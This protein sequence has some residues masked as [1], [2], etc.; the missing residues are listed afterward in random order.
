ME[1]QVCG[2]QSTE[3][4]VMYVC[5]GGVQGL[6][7]TVLRVPKADDVAHHLAAPFTLIIPTCFEV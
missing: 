5:L 3:E 4:G 1:R 7:K 2:G 6:V